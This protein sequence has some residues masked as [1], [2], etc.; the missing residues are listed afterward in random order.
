MTKNQ[1]YKKAAEI[2]EEFR[3]KCYP[4]GYYACCAISMVVCANRPGQGFDIEEC[5]LFDSYFQ[6]ESGTLTWLDELNLSDEETKTRRVLALLFMAE[7]A[8]DEK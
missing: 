5:K 6:P 8:K 4:K 7:I 2:V 3:P 1:I